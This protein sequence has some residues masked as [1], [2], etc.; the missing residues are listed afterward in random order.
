MTRKRKTVLPALVLVTL[1]LGALGPDID[2]AHADCLN[3]VIYVTRAG[4]AP[5]YVH[6]EHDPCV[7]ETPWNQSYTYHGELTRPGLPLGAPNG[8]WIDL[9]IPA[10]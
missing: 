1:V 2:R 5:T 3:A 9:G 10:P 4:E 8:Y 6:G 7:T